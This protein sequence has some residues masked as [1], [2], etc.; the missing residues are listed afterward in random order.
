MRPIRIEWSIKGYHYFRIRPDVGVNLRVEPEENNA[1]DPYAM[2]V[3]TPDG[4]Q[5]GRVPANLCRA[6]RE[7]LTRDLCL[8][9]IQC[10]FTGEVRQSDN[11]NVFQR[12]RP[13]A[14]H[15]RPGGGA[16][17]KCTYKLNIR[18]GKFRRAL[19]VFEQYV[20]FNDRDRCFYL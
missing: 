3:L 19:Q 9:G 2:K 18:T 15:D 13:G 7:I 11:P 6:F 16:E 10:R 17:L 5:I 8:G 1:Y 14:R 4:R 20:P 12:Y